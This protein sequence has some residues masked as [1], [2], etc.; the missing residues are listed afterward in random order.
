MRFLRY[1]LSHRT[2]YDY[3]GSVSVSHHLLRLQPRDLSH[4]VC[5]Q[6]RLI[7]EPEPAVVNQC[8]DYF[9]N[10]RHFVTLEGAHGSLMVNSESE[11]AVAPTYVPEPEET[12]AWTIARGMLLVDQTRNGLEAKEFAYAS[13]RVMVTAEAAAYAAESFPAGRPLLEAALDLTARIHRD[14]TFDPAATTVSTSVPEIMKVRKG[15]CQDFSHLQLACFRSQGLAARYVS[16]YLETDPPPGQEKMVGS[17]ASHAWVSLYCPG[18]GWIDLD[19][20]NNCV[21]S[22]RHITVA[23]GRDYGDVSPIRGVVVGDGSH[24]LAVAVDV[25]PLGPMEY[26]SA[27]T[28]RDLEATVTASELAV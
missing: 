13:P 8:P 24:S 14:F 17:D 3:T 4:Q 26:S 16:G 28:L 23:W 22:M 7:I 27:A 9:G 2:S 21:P 20:T 15:V 10:H 18:H 12:P 11:V 1:R 19:P 6:H 5:L 25:N